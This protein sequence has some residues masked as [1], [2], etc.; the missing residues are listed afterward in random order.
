MLFLLIYVFL[1]TDITKS[2][3]M[4]LPAGDSTEKKLDVQSPHIPLLGG[5]W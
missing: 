1:G 3:R 2:S 5:L 4:F